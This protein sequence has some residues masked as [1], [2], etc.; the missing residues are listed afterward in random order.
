MH[1]RKLQVSFSSVSILFLNKPLFAFRNTGAQPKRQPAI[2]PP[3][4]TVTLCLPT[5]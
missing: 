2:T 5:L 1:S 3:L 4:A